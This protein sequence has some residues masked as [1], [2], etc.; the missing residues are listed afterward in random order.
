MSS[1]LRSSKTLFTQGLLFY[2]QGPLFCA[3]GPLFCALVREEAIF[4]ACKLCVNEDFACM[5]RE[6]EIIIIVKKINF[7][8][9][10]HVWLK[11]NLGK[12]RFSIFIWIC[13]IKV[14]VPNPYYVSNASQ[15]NWNITPCREKVEKYIVITVQLDQ[16]DI[17]TT[18]N[19]NFFK[20]LDELNKI[21]LIKA[22]A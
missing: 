5:C 7:D 4:A 20:S 8:N 16:W 1:I 11:K 17:E 21:T 9:W 13:D 12:N 3:L 14:N 15:K 22:Y 2:T 19:F 18:C 6:K 10:I